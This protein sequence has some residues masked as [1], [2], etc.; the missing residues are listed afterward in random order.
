[1]NVWGQVLANSDKFAREQ[2]LIGPDFDYRNAGGVKGN[3]HFDDSGKLPNHPTFSKGSRYADT[4][5]KEYAALMNPN[6][7]AKGYEPNTTQPGRW[8]GKM[9]IPSVDQ[10]EA[11]GAE[12]Y[13]RYFNGPAESGQGSS[14]KKPEGLGNI[15]K[16][17]IK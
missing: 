8:E 3:G 17:K 15:H 7:Y 2:G 14:W 1:M 9:F 13:N 5:S 4:A 16:G 6:N 10:L 11:N 12:F